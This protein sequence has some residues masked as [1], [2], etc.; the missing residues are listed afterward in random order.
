[1]P[2]QI[3]VRAEA[4][5]LRHC[6]QVDTKRHVPTNALVASGGFTTILSLIYIGSPT[7]FYAIVSLFVV[8]ILQC[9]L[10]SIGSILWRRVYH[11]ASLPPT[12]W[13]LGRWGVAVNSM[14]VVYATWA[15]FWAFWPQL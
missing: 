2:L 11:P 13:S 1:M 5:L 3:H 4:L 15:W 9:Y 12:Q 6:C 7:A 10:F 8:S 14:A